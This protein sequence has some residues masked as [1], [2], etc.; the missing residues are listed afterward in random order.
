MLLYQI[1]QGDDTTTVKN[2]MMSQLS[3]LASLQVTAGQAPKLGSGGSIAYEMLQVKAG[4]GPLDLTT[5]TQ[6]FLDEY[7]TSQFP[8]PDQSIP[9]F[10]RQGW[11]KSHECGYKRW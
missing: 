9:S 5:R 11:D 2:R 8:L 7:L 10:L 4:M 1:K 6:P 3:V